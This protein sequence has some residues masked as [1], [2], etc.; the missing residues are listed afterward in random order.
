[1]TKLN[2]L[3]FDLKWI[4]DMIDAGG[5]KVVV[6]GKK[7]IE[8]ID[9]SIRFWPDLKIATTEFIDKD[10]YVRIN[11]TLKEKLMNFGLDK[12]SRRVIVV[13]PISCISM[14][15]FFKRERE[16]LCYV[17]FRSSDLAKFEDDYYFILSQCKLVALF[18]GGVNSCRGRIHFGSLHKYLVTRNCEISS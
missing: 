2:G 16:L 1:M 14:I 4:S 5:E 9:E 6:D 17:Y 13:D 7:T 11:R 3:E 10:D 18:L 12:N 15:Q 8:M